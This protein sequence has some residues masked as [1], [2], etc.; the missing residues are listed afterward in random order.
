M[1][2]DHDQPDRAYPA[3]GPVLFLHGY[4]DGLVQLAALFVRPET[5]PEPSVTT[6]QG[7]IEAERLATIDGMTVL[8]YSFT[9]PARAD[10]TYSMHGAALPVHADFT[11]D[12][13]IAYVSCNGQESGDRERSTNERNALW[14]RLARQHADVPFQ[15]LLNGGDQ[16]YADE[17]LD[18]DPRLHAWRHGESEEPLDEAD[19]AALRARLRSYLLQRY[20]ELYAQP[21]PA[22]LMARIPILCMWD[23]H[24]I[25]DGWGSLPETQLDSPMGR[26]VFETARE[27]FLLFQLAAHPA[28]PPPICPDRA[29]TSLSWRVQL[30]GVALI[31]PDLRSERRPDQ[32]MGPVGRDVFN[33]ALAAAED[34]QVFVLSSVPALGPRL[35]WVE[36]AMQQSPRMEKYQDDLRDQWQSRAHRDEWRV[37]LEHLLAVHERGGCRLSV[38][39][40]E[41]HLATRGTMAAPSGPLHQ[42]VASG[43]THPAPPKAYARALGILARLGESPVPGH[44][45]RLHPLPG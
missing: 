7:P 9:L 41:I 36:A 16:L 27:L 38:L 28:E 13:R 19:A 37:F 26:L 32:I 23:D 15:V 22:W 40:G 11:R 29:G 17:M 1:N 35:S 43:I 20:C 2:S 8:R 25:C 3:V 33:E 21:A 6:H 5:A 42:L 45:I 44:P 14:Q 10:A 39:S 4:A 31:A 34:G 24:D 12:L 30:P 18:E